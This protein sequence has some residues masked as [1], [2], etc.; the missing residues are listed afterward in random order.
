MQWCKKKIHVH[1][2]YLLLTKCN[3]YLLAIYTSEYLL[4][5]DSWLLFNCWNWYKK[6]FIVNSIIRLP[7]MKS[8]VYNN[9]FTKKW[10]IDL[11]ILTLAALKKSKQSWCITWWPCV[12]YLTSMDWLW[13]WL[14]GCLYVD[15]SAGADCGR[16]FPVDS[17]SLHHS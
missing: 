13:V 14:D 5:R 8:G 11:H 7:Q 12:W 10:S 16:R 2:Q 15:V 3:R 9:W 1:V 4:L 6:V 17:D